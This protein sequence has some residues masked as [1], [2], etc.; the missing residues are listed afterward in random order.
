MNWHNFLIAVTGISGG[1]S[2][3]VT[4]GLWITDDMSGRTALVLVTVGILLGS[5]AIGVATS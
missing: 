5:I 4:F 3:V 2:V 1:L